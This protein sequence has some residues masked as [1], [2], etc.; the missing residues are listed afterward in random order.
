MRKLSG[1]WEIYPRFEQHNMDDFYAEIDVLLFMSQFGLAIREA[2]ARG[3]TVIQTDS[4]GT[5]EH[6]AVRPENL[7]PIAAPPNRLRDAI[8]QV[9]QKDKRNRPVYPVVCFDDQAQAFAALVDQVL[10]DTERAA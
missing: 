7:I 8:T 2:L 9:L 4:G 5:V 1:T 3:I 10:H 6:G